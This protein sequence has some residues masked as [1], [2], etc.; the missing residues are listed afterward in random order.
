VKNTDILIKL[1]PILNGFNS[2]QKIIL[3]QIMSNNDYS[4]IDYKG[5][6]CIKTKE[7]EIYNLITFVKSKCNC[8]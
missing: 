8:N 3:S 5:D 6:I 2:K 4:F 7:G 1:K